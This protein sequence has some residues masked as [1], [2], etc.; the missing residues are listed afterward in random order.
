MTDLRKG[1]QGEAV[2]KLQARLNQGGWLKEDGDFGPVTEE[3]V[4]AFQS[5]RKLKDDGIVG[6]KTEAELDAGSR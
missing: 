2:K 3:A 5:S 1:A 6:P 4:K